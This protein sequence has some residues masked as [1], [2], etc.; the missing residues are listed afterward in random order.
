MAIINPLTYTI[1]NGT[2]VD[3]TPVQANFTQIVQDVNANAAPVGGNASQ[4]FLVAPTNNPAG[5]VPLAQLQQQLTQVGTQTLSPTASSTITPVAF[6]TLVYPNFSAAGTV[7]VSPG[8]F[9]GQRVC[10]YGSAYAVTIQTNVTSGSPFLAFPDG[11][12]SYSWT[13]P[14]GFTEQYIEMVWDGANWRCTT[15]GQIIAAPATAS[16]QVVTLGQVALPSNGS[17]AD[18]TRV[19]FFG[20]TYTNF[21]E[22]PLLVQIIVQLDP[23]AGAGVELFVNGV[24]VSCFYTPVAV[25]ISGVVTAIVP[26]GQTYQLVLASGSGV[27]NY[28]YEY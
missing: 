12:T 7:I 23:I 4:Q 6:N 9:S 8:A 3:A 1:T 11:S 5:A 20:R 21:S 26:P 27:F 14:A 2:P 10:V 17:Y 13:I 18:F 24:V 19:R 15:M 28:W 16:N 25:S 22:N